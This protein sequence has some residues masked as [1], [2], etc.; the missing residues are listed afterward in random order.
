MTL[1]PPWILTGSFGGGSA[2]REC[3]AQTPVAD[4]DI[5]RA[6]HG[7]LLTTQRIPIIEGGRGERA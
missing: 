1:A 4:A 7:D 2:E 5:Q 6:G 3:A